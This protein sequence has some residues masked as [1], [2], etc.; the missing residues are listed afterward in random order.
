MNVLERRDESMCSD[1]VKRQLAFDE[2]QV[3][4]LAGNGASHDSNSL[5]A[6]QSIDG[7]SPFQKSNSAISG[8][9]TAV[10]KLLSGQ[11]HHQ[12][13][14]TLHRRREAREGTVSHLTQET[15]AC[16]CLSNRIADEELPAVREEWE[17]SYAL[18]EA[19]VARLDPRLQ[20]RLLCGKSLPF[21]QALASGSPS[22]ATKALSG[23]LQRCA[24]VAER[25]RAAS[26]LVKGKIDVTFECSRGAAS[27]S[28]ADDERRTLFLES[29]ALQHQVETAKKRVV[30][31]SVVDE[32]GDLPGIVVAAEVAALHAADRKATAERQQLEA[33]CEEFRARLLSAE[34]AERYVLYQLA[35]CDAAELSERDTIAAETQQETLNLF[36]NFAAIIECCFE[37]ELRTAEIELERTELLL[38]DGGSA[39][40]L[41]QTILDVKQQREQHLAQLVGT[42]RDI[43]ALGSRL[44]EALELMPV[45][46][47]E[48]RSAAS[49]EANVKALECACAQKCRVLD[50]LSSEAFERHLIDKALGNDVWMP[51]CQEAAFSQQSLALIE[52]YRTLH[53]QVLLLSSEVARVD[54]QL[55][56]REDLS[57]LTL[58][59]ALEE[60]SRTQAAE[61]ETL[62]QELSRTSAELA[63][64]SAEVS[65]ALN[66]RARRMNTTNVKENA[67]E[68][69]RNE[70][71]MIEE[72]CYDL[73]SAIEAHARS[74]QQFN[75][76]EKTMQS[77]RHERY[78]QHMTAQQQRNRKFRKRAAPHTA[79]AESRSAS[80]AVSQ[81]ELYLQRLA[82][83]AVR[84]EYV[85]IP[86]EH[87]GST[88]T[89]ASWW[90][91]RAWWNSTVSRPRS[92]DVLL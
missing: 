88:A 72:A 70:T 27:T 77:T 12:L 34:A 28:A 87:G 46:V 32:V 35:A 26:A 24:E 30:I 14:E 5:E 69:V 19:K 52:T 31:L 66:E 89:D 74:K 48:A 38:T 50:R 55:R 67:I 20:R 40:T 10:K 80:A 60:E 13:I 29:D 63:A 42:N 39:G 73:R 7:D 75:M 9:R 43:S 47:D 51:D 49:V 86:P 61:R 15:A 3:A 85:H 76:D 22:Q 90:W 83:A 82:S 79:L 91:P 81:R 53:R 68:A 78:F 57:T 4:S 54:E 37:H 33:R 17:S 36:S 45:D 59:S 18:L 1:I 23:V 64:A 41:E 62:E 44:D 21:T 11:Q 92:A 6:P 56:M 2:T 65:E 58:F 8:P 16:V 25:S 71:D 84:P